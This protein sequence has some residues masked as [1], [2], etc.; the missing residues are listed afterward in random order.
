MKTK[1][2]IAKLIANRK[3]D[4]RPHA[5]ETGNGAVIEVVLDGTASRPAKLTLD[6]EW[7]SVQDLRELSKLAKK[8]A[9]ALEAAGADADA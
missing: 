3:S 8:L 9:E 2:A 7:V 1:Q 4:I 5:F 6:G